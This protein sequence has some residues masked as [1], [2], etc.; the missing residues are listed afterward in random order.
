MNK[1]LFR[2][3]FYNYFKNENF[4]DNFFFGKNL[5]QIIFS[6]EF[7]SLKFTKFFQTD[8]GEGPLTIMLGKN[9]FD[10]KNAGYGMTSTFDANLQKGNS[11]SEY[12]PW[13][14]GR[15]VYATDKVNIFNTK[16]IFTEKSI[17]RSLT[18]IFFF[19]CINDPFLNEL[20]FLETIKIQ[21]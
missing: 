6:S 20:N 7:V 17:R 9:V 4:L 13:K 15:V 21:V 12:D 18:Q 16:N 2:Y 14:Y 11:F 19:I 3:I 10:D 1:K 8:N 5:T